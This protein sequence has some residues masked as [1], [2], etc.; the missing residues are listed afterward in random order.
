VIQVHKVEVLIIDHDNVGPEGL[1]VLLENTHYPNRAIAP[2][3]M[4]CVT[5]EVEWSDS[6]PLNSRQHQAAAY[7]ELFKD[8]EKVS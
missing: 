2:N 7:Q 5:R 4:G 6:H 1:K 8:S 3:V